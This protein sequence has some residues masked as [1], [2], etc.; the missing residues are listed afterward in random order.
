MTRTTKTTIRLGLWLASIA[1]VIAMGLVYFPREYPGMGFWESLY[2]TLRLFVFEHDLPNFPRSWQLIFIHFAAPVI[3]ISAVGT[4]VSYLF[5]FSPAIRTRF[6]S[7]HVVICGVGRTGKLVAATL[8]RRGVPV[9]GV[10]RGPIEAFDEWRSECGVPMIFGDFNRKS[11]M[12]RAGAR[13]ARSIIFSSGDD[14]AN[15]EG[16]VGAYDLLHTD[17]GPARLIWA[18]VATERLA[19]T[20]RLA[21]RTKGR[22]SIRFFDTYHLAA[23]RMI[24]RHF[25]REIRKGVS[26]VTILGFGKFGHDVLEILVHDLGP[27]EKFIIKVI[28]KHDRSALVRSLAQEL[29]VA[30][31]VSFTQASVQDLDLVDEPDK[32]F[33]LC[34]DDDLGNL[35][36]AMMLASKMGATHIYVRMTRWPLSAVADHLGEDRGVTFI[37]INELMVQGIEQLP[38]V[39]APASAEHLKRVGSA[40]VTIKETSQ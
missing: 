13:R 21:V 32:A 40:E 16:A 3:A 37:N 18:H 34:T 7:D 10:D 22:I 33:F 24:S 35:T 29:G 28:D 30:D 8:K 14:L 31:R 26:E 2:Y 27:N 19:E 25:N 39:F 15:L 17:A 12:I 20:A 6:M 23:E 11:P 9:V 4:A 38:G 36:A 5:R 1:A